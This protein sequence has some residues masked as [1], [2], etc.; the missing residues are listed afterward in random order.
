MAPW[1]PS[2]ILNMTFYILCLK[3]G[4]EMG[5]I[6]LHR[7]G[8]VKLACQR[9]NDVVLKMHLHS[10]WEQFHLGWLITER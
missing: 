9:I 10:S 6:N 1:Q 4:A 2:V 7:N 8:N 3:L 5:Q